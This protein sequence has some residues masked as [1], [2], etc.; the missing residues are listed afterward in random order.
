VDENSRSVGIVWDGVELEYLLTFLMVFRAEYIPQLVVEKREDKFQS[1]KQESMTVAQYTAKFN[2]L[3][4]Y[5]R[6]LV[7]IERNQTQ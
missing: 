6:C 1:L 3:S 7:D 4:K 2:R 5:C